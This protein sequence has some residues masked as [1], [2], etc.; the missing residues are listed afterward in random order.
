MADKEE[1]EVG[2]GYAGRVEKASSLGDNP[3][4]GDQPVE[5]Y[6]VETVKADKPYKT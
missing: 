1:M 6:T 2:E 4:P 3:Q 5:S